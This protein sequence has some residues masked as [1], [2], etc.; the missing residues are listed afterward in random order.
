MAC[1]FAGQADSLAHFY[2]V[3]TQGMDATSDIPADRWNVALD[4]LPQSIRHGGFLRRN[5]WE[6]DHQFFSISPKEAAHMDPQ[7]RILLEQTYHA[8]E[9]ANIDPETVKG[10]NCGVFIGLGTQDYSRVMHNSGEF[11]GFHSKGS[12]GSMAAGRIAYHFDLIG[13][14]FVVDTACSSS[15]VA[16]HQAVK[17]LQLNQC[18]LAIVGGVTLILTVDYNLDLASAGLLAKDGRCKPFSKAADGFARGEGVG[19]IILQR[20]QEALNDKR[21]IYANILGS[22]IN[23][24]GKTNGITAPSKES[25][26]RV[27]KEALKDAKLSAEAINYVETHGTGTDLGDKIEFS[28]LSEIYQGR[29]QPLYIGSVKGNIAHCEAAAGIAGV[30]KTSLCIYHHIVPP[31]TAANCLNPEL[32]RDLCKAEF[33]AQIIVKQNIIGAVSSFGM[34]GSNAHVILGAEESSN[35]EL[36]SSCTTIPYPYLALSAKSAESMQKLYDAYRILL[37]QSD[38]KAFNALLVQANQRKSWPGYRQLVFGHNKAALL[39][40]LDNVDTVASNERFAKRKAKLAFMFTGQGGVYKDMTRLL[41]EVIPLYRNILDH[42]AAKLDACIEFPHKIKRYIF[43]D[44]ASPTLDNAQAAQL[45]LFL[46]EFSLAKLLNQLRVMPDFVIGHSLGEYAAACTAGILSFEH[47]AQMVNQRSLAIS[48]YPGLTH[49]VMVQIYANS[50]VVEDLVNELKS[51]APELALWLS[52]YNA[53][54]IQVVSGAGDAVERLLQELKQRHIHSVKLNTTHAFHTPLLASAAHYFKERLIASGISFSTA[55]TRPVFIST[56]E[57]YRVDSKNDDFASMDYWQA[58]IVNP[59]RFKQAIEVGYELGVTSFIEIGPDSVLTSLASH[60]L[61][62]N[63][64]FNELAFLA[65]NGKNKADLDLFFNLLDYLYKANRL[66]SQRLAALLNAK[67]A[68]DS[69]VFLPAYPFARTKLL[70]DYLKTNALSA[71]SKKRLKPMTLE[72]THLEFQINLDLAQAENAYIAQHVIHEM[73]ILPGSYYITTS[74]DLIEKLKDTYFTDQSQM[75]I[76]MDNL[77]ILRPVIFSSVGQESLKVVIRQQSANQFKLTYF[78][79]PEQDKAVCEAS[80]LLKSKEVSNRSLCPYQTVQPQHAE[81]FYTNYAAKGV[82][83]GS[84]FR[85]QKA[86]YILDAQNTVSELAPSESELTTHA[87]FLD[88]CFQTMALGLD[89]LEQAYAPTAIRHIKLYKEDNWKTGL[90][91]HAQIIAHT[92]EHLE[93]NLTIYNA[94]NDV[95]MEMDGI[96]CQSVKLQT[97]PNNIIHN[98]SLE[99]IVYLTQD[100]ALTHCALVADL[101][102][103]QTQQLQRLLDSKHGVPSMDWCELVGGTTIRTGH[104]LI[105]IEAMT[106]EKNELLNITTHL[107]SMSREK[108]QDVETKRDPGYLY[109]LFQTVY[110]FLCKQDEQIPGHL[111]TIS[112]V[113][114]TQSADYKNLICSLLKA[115]TLAFPTEFPTIKFR[116]FAYDRF[117]EENVTYLFANHNETQVAQEITTPFWAVHGNELYRCKTKPH[118]L[119]QKTQPTVLPEEGHYLVTGG[120]GGVGKT[121]LKHMVTNLGL[122]NFIVTYRHFELADQSFIDELT[123]KYQANILCRCVDVASE[124]QLSKLVKTLPRP[125]SGI[126]HLAGVNT[127]QTL[128]KTSIKSMEKVLAAKVF[129]AWLLHE[130]TQEFT[131]LQVF[132]LFSSLATLIS[133]PGQFDYALANLGLHEL[134]SYRHKKNLPITVIDW[135]P[136]AKTGMMANIGAH[137]T[138][139]IP[140]SKFEPLLPAM[141]NELLFTCLTHGKDHHFAVFKTHT[142]S[143]PDQ[144]SVELEKISLS[145]HSSKEEAAKSIKTRLLQLIAQE[146]N[147]NALT[148]NDQI[149]L[150]ELGMDSINTIRI[151][152]ELQTE[153]GLNIP[154]SVLLEETTIEAVTQQ[155]VEMWMV[156]QQVEHVEPETEYPVNGNQNNFYRL[157]YNQFSIWYE[158]QSVE[159]NTAY[160]CSIG[161]K[162]SG[163][164]IHLEQIEATWATLINTHEMLRAMFTSKEGTLGYEILPVSQALKQQMIV[165]ETIDTAIDV[166]KYLQSRLLREIDFSR[167]LPTKIFIIHQ[168]ND[169]YLM[170]S[171]HHIVMD[172]AAMFQVGEKLLRS[173]CEPGFVLKMKPFVASYHEFVQQQNQQSTDYNT[174]ALKFLLKEVLNED[175]ELRVFELPRK[176]LSALPDLARGGT[177]AIA[178]TEDEMQTILSL[179]M[180]IRVHLCLS[181]W[182]LLLAKY[183]GEDNILVGIAFNGR[184]QKK[185]AE[186]VGHFVNVLPLCIKIDQKETCNHF[187]NHVRHHLIE[188]ME[189]QDFPLVKLMMHPE[190]KQ[191]LQGRPLLQTYF[192]YFDA[193]ELDI[194]ICN[195]SMAIQPLVYPQQEAQFQMSLWVTYETNRYAFEIKY[196]AELFSEKLLANFTKH[197]KTILISLSQ[198]LLQKQ[199]MPKLSDIQLL[200]AAEITKCLPPEN[201]QRPTKFVYDYFVEQT[202]CFP[203]AIAIEMREQKITYEQLQRWVDDMALAL[204]EFAQTPDETVAILSPERA[205]IEFIVTV[206]A[207]WKQGL[208]YVPLNSHHPLERI[209]YVL[210]TVGCEKI[211]VIDNPDAA[212]KGFLLSGAKLV[213]DVRVQSA[214]L[215]IQVIN[216]PVSTTVE[217]IDESHRKTTSPLAYIL[218]TSGSTGLPKGVLIEQDGLIER[219]LWMKNY[220]NF[221]PEDKFLQSTSVTFDVSLPEYCLPLICGATM[222]LFHP[223]D[224]PNAHAAICTQHQVTMMSTVPSLFSILL[225]DLSQC[226]TLKHLI[227]IGEVL[228]PAIVNQWLASGTS[229]V[230][231]NLYGPTEVTV[232][233]TAY[234]CREPIR[235]ASVP[236]GEVSDHVIPLVLDKYGSLVPEQVIGELY[237]AGSGVA[238]GY[239]GGQLKSNPFV[240]NPF[241]SRYTR[242][243]KTGDF[244]RWLDDRTLEYIGRKDNRVKLHGLLVE[245]GEIEECVLKAFPEIKNAC[246]LVVEFKIN[247]TTIKHIVLCLMPDCVDTKGIMHHLGQHLPK[248]M[249]PWKIMVFAEFPRNSSAKVDRKVLASLVRKDC[250]EE[251]KSTTEKGESTRKPVT[252]LE[253]ACCKIWESLL[254]KSNIGIDENFFE[255]GGDSLLL[256]QMTLQVEKELNVKANFA[257]FL[258]NPTID[259]LLNGNR[260]TSSIWKKELTLLNEIPPFHKARKTNAVLLTGG[261]G[262]LGLHVLRALLDHTEKQVYLIVRAE[263][264]GQARK[265]LTERFARVFS[266]TIDL[267]RV[268]IYGGDLA[269]STLGLQAG[270]FHHV[271]GAISIIIHAAAEV[272]HVVDYARL[273]TN[274]VLVSQ[275]ML[276][277]ARIANCTHFFHMSTQFSEINDLPESYMSEARISEF[278]SGYEQSKFIAELLMHA[279]VKQKYPVTTLRL[280]LIIDG[281]DPLL[282]RQNHF[283]AFVIKC[284]RLGGYPDLPLS[285]AVLATADVAELIAKQCNE[286]ALESKVYNCLNHSISLHELF[287]FLNSQLAFKANK[288]EPSLWRKQVIESTPETDP[289]YKLLPLYTSSLLIS[290]KVDERKLE[291]DEF[292]K[293]V[294][295][296]GVTHEIQIRKIGTL[297]AQYFAVTQLE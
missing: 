179:P 269:H 88:N 154:L 270:D 237:L 225:S 222:V 208:S 113:S 236:I 251:F 147:H 266:R 259:A 170:L 65:I 39:Q 190:V 36:N 175:K 4:T 81:K 297:L 12:L 260:T 80:L 277:L 118:E 182:A 159:N 151:R 142:L 279:A 218:F 14:N 163:N 219:L 135:G 210:D 148:I 230:L 106:L 20:H 75:Q 33:P 145:Q 271:C 98:I 128:A 137:S 78:C 262:H 267:S 122:K 152:S 280:P 194:N 24:D 22:A 254:R 224:N 27:I 248:Y 43:N 126:F 205:N 19:V 231:Y 116:Y 115:M 242:M 244:V 5:P 131:E 169:V 103:P 3:I 263:D 257:K 41:Y 193:S 38:E 7:H 26:K 50:N 226:A 66:D 233:A 143:Q 104:L 287:G 293:A 173:L 220:F 130:L 296:D 268:C 46:I 291:H 121:M 217:A 117:T 187:I 102:K 203:K 235:S 89:Q 42:Y 79:L 212:I 57:E 292:R 101:K 204:A 164:A 138:S 265:R 123:K 34:S 256:T 9:D 97:L 264:D 141:C 52:V 227:M 99:K 45:S 6:F 177:V 174:K 286:N 192:N 161:W 176:T 294:E 273:K 213:L 167:E 120:L 1:E 221:S 290:D 172:A 209:K 49:G 184:T 31:H 250:E 249:L 186:V 129:S 68:S 127:D 56:A 274:N 162:I 58:Q 281:T 95:L 107:S 94:Q 87:A 238:R 157:S 84:L 183:T 252:T 215:T 288:L 86:Y 276:N 25:Q 234:P 185:W 51:E 253:K 214:A 71:M 247:E 110:H 188:L 140:L 61:K 158:Q 216:A 150:S 197:F 85:K 92:E 155:L 160:H 284:L 47:A 278:S 8:F 134:A 100:E 272:N 23:S 18:D 55:N 77:L 30:I 191:S 168:D 146:T 67:T 136:W 70:P 82:N 149:A 48:E 59:V 29:E 139:S 240:D 289:F 21:R 91:C 17:A 10:T 153:L 72:P 2:E 124:N 180:N 202:L 11:T 119:T 156:N 35:Q 105:V 28:A 199:S 258:A 37:Q 201:A 76:E 62:G 125:L 13:P 171:S 54:E 181:A 229:C 74:L 64:R 189:F 15:L 90:R 133:S 275:N 207:L 283:V 40:Q 63:E 53:P 108:L 144:V 241:Q 165:V 285:F 73:C 16:L 93:A 255:L 83:Y 282:L 69:S 44:E 295:A 111:K 32:R 198:A 243:Y 178:F 109:N 211:I 195:K 132:V 114:C 239:I 60:C 223:D 200:S 245:L 112:F 96:V 261:A 206:L 166:K 196:Q 228:P 232:Y 246:A